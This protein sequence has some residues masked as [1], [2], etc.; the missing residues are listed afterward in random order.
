V[1]Q[2]HIRFCFLDAAIADAFHE[3]FGGKRFLTH[4][5]S[6]GVPP[7]REFDI[8]APTRRTAMI[9]HDA[10]GLVGANMCSR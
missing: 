3:R 4:H 1:Q 9:N 10:G 7:V 8:S 2:F 6:P 5:S